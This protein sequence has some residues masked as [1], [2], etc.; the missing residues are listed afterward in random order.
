MMYQLKSYLIELYRGCIKRGSNNIKI[1]RLKEKVKG[2]GV[3]C[4]N[5]LVL[6]LMYAWYGWT[7]WIH[8]QVTVTKET[9]NS[10][11]LDSREKKKE[12]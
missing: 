2:G 5:I 10:A 1:Q 4:F 12:P 6:I 3:V 11:Q 8:E 9:K 7:Y